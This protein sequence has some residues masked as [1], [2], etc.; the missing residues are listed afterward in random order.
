MT[1]LAAEND[2]SLRRECPE[3]KACALVSQ[4]IITDIAVKAGFLTVPAASV[5]L[6]FHG[7]RTSSQVLT[8]GEIRFKLGLSSIR[9]YAYVHH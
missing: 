3:F 6:Q 5:S 7:L 8:W 9:E 4:T 2:N 1:V